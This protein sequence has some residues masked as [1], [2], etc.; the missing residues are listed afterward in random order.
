MDVTVPPLHFVMD[1]TVPP[2]LRPAALLTLG[3]AL[4][5]RQFWGPQLDG[6]RCAR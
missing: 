2:A 1:V 6:G 4:S 5:G 3:D